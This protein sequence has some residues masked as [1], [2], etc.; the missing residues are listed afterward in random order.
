MLGVECA[1]LTYEIFENN[2]S[3]YGVLPALILQEEISVS[4][5]KDT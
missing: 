3:K 4:P 2:G 5:R 1:S